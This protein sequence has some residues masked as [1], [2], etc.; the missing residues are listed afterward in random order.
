MKNLIRN[1]KDVWS[2]RVRKDVDAM[3]SFGVGLDARRGTCLGPAASR[4][5]GTF[6]F[7]LM[8]KSD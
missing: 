4:G 1:K 3:H 5:L 2:A 6:F 7:V 8:P